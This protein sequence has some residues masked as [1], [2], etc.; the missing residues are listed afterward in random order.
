MEGQRKTIFAQ[1]FCYKILY[2]KFKNVKYSSLSK[3]YKR[4]QNLKFAPKNREES[5]VLKN[6]AD[7]NFS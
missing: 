6:F 1:V 7:S 3:I 5:E 4:I 2:L